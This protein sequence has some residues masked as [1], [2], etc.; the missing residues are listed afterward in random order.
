MNSVLAVHEEDK[1]LVRIILDVPKV[2]KYVAV[3]Q[4]ILNVFLPGVGTII[5]PCFGE[6]IVNKTQIVI[7]ILQMLTMWTLFIGWIWAVCWS[8]L[9]I[10]KAWGW[11]A[12]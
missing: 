1:A 9:I 5:T 12:S 2:N 7:G 6:G 11:G 4:L 10:R 3:A 8:A